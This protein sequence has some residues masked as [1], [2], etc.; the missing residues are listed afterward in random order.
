MAKRQL[1]IAG[2]ERPK[3]KEIDEAAEAYRDVRDRRMKATIKE[4]D[5]KAE[6]MAAVKK[7][8]AELEGPADGKR[9]YVYSDGEE[10]FEVIYAPE[11]NVKVREF[12]PAA[13]GPQDGD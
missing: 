2:A 7:H 13:P 8:L 1:E 12:K 11:E 5:A 9:S 6:L 4:A 3:I 10:S